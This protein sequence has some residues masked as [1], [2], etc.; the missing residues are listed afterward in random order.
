MF[1]SFYAEKHMFKERQSTTRYVTSL[2]EGF[3]GA[4][5]DGER[6]IDKGAKNDTDGK[7][8][9]RMTGKTISR[10]IS[11]VLVKLY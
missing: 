4:K 1:L 7:P 11:I 6:E 10:E 8:D 5:N 3:V 9:S 2:N